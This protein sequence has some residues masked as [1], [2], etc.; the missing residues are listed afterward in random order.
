MVEHPGVRTLHRL[1]EVEI[2]AVL[3][4]RASCQE[5]CKQKGTPE[6]SRG[7]KI[8]HTLIIQS[9]PALS[10]KLPP[11]TISTTMTTP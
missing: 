4:G 7:G 8:S 9:L 5:A 3:D 1:G 11:P 2:P 6:G 10:K